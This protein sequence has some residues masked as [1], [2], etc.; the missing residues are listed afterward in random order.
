MCLIFAK[1]GK[2]SLKKGDEK[3]WYYTNMERELA[4][5]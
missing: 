1:G 2:N 4:G 3:S 5:K